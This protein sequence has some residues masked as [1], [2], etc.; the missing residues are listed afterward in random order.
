MQRIAFNAANGKRRLLVVL[1][2]LAACSLLGAFA[3]G[4]AHAA[5][6]DTLPAPHDNT[7]SGL[8]RN[9]YL[10]STDNGYMRLFVQGKTVHVEYYDNAFNLTSKKTVKLELPVWGGFHKGGDGSY[11]L[12]EGQNNEDDVDGTEVVR[13]IKYDANWNRVGAGKVL[14]EEG[15]DY[16]IRYPFDYACVNMTEVDGKLYVVTGRE[17]YVDERY[18]QGHQGMMLIRMDE[19]SFDTEVVD[20][21]FWHSF[22]QYIDHK[23]SNIYL[24]ELSEGSRATMLSRFDAGN[25]DAENKEESIPVFPYGGERT[26]AWAISCYASVDDLALSGENVLG[27]GTSIDQGKYDNVDENTPYN[28]YLTVTPCSDLSEEATSVVWL[29]SYKE[30][31]GLAGV[32]LTKI[33]DDRFLVTWQTEGGAISDVND[34]LSGCTLHYRFIDGSGKAIG[35]E[36][37][38]KATTSDCHPILKGGNVVFYASDDKT[39]DFYT[40]SASSGEF[41]EKTYRS[42]GNGLTW[43]VSKNVLTISGNGSL[44]AEC[45]W[46]MF[47][48]AV[49]K[50]VIKGGVER[51]GDSAFNFLDS[52]QKVVV[53]DGVK[54]IG[55][56]AFAYIDN[57]KVVEIPASVTKIGADIIWTG[58]YWV[59]SNSHV[60]QATIRAPK[61]S[62]AHKYAKKHGID[63]DPLDSAGNATSIK[64]AKV[65]GIKNKAYTG[66]KIKQKP[67][68]KVDGKKLVAGEDYQ[69]SYKQNIEVGTATVIISGIG[70]YQG[71]VSKTF[72][73]KKA[74]NPLKVTPA[75]KSFKRSALGK[76]KTLKIAASKSKGKLTYAPNKKAKAAKIKVSAKGKVT[77]PKNCKKGTY[78]IVVKAAGNKSYK[79]ATATVKIVVK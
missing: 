39:V 77:I 71:K 35:G 78:K 15:W 74:A 49:K 63:F 23:G 69:L 26:S 12:V 18:G 8:I 17:G 70:D 59:G 40:I 32:K 29:T 65:S 7:W 37:T 79:P 1:V 48:G 76:A 55:K 47:E 27:I 68:V 34:P 28:I 41:S 75:S 62:Y 30:P 14:A 46:S 42:L 6:G 33:D 25:A 20:G 54:S 58:S 60:Y 67:V 11:Y 36:R 52:V 19:K 13:I 24:Y 2:T 72:K 38:A 43:K 64:G 50:I 45:N 9:S 44:E 61:G 66:K 57:L 51:I 21:D 31:V 4:I 56:E 53:C 73:I 3:P 5:S 10:E 22:A 16:E